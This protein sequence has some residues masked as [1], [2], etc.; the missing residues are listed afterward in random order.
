[1]TDKTDA[2]LDGLRQALAYDLATGQFTW[3]QQC[4]RKVKIGAR[5]GTIHRNQLRRYVTVHRK[6]HACARLAWLFVT[7]EWPKGQIDHIDG[8]ALND[9]FSNLRDVDQRTNSENV[10]RPRAH[11]TL[12]VQ[13][14]RR[15]KGK[16]SA[17][18][19]VDGKE[20][21]LGTFAT[22]DEALEAYVNAKRRL[23]EGCTL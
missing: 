15:M 18:V 22:P 16:F 21:G 1:M 13:G 7:G 11:N 20:V 14:V 3:R 9:A 12:G 6:K 5:A 2:I 4:A 10:R 19:I 23:H 17:R 8:N